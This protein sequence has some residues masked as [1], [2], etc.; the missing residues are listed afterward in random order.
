MRKALL[1]VAPLLLVGCQTWGPTWSEVSGARYYNLATM[2]RL[3]AVISRIDDQGAF[4]QYPIKVEPGRHEI[5]LQGTLRGWSGA[6][7]E[8]MVL[9]LE[10]CKRYYLNAQYQN[11]IQP[12]FTPVVDYVDDIAGCGM[13]ASAK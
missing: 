13:V 8:T 7:F 11:T 6:T 12:R 10:P 4:A 5:R 1:L 2:Y 3:P 9:T